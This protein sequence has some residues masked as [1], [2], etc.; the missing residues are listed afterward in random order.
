[1]KYDDLL[2]TPASLLVRALDLRIRRNVIDDSDILQV[3]VF[4]PIDSTN[5][6]TGPDGAKKIGAVPEGSMFMTLFDNDS[7]DGQDDEIALFP[8]T[9]AI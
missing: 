5:P 4:L 9:T 2:K 6:T 7:R 3:H 8:C 1:M